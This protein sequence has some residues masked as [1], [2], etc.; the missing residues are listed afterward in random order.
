[1]ERLREIP[2]PKDVEDCIV[3][4]WLYCED[5]SHGWDRVGLTQEGRDQLGAW[6]SGY[7]DAAR[8]VAPGWSDSEPEITVELESDRPTMR[9]LPPDWMLEACR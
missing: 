8:P 7:Q 1:V 9:C 4:G 2:I 6:E 3:L 5:A